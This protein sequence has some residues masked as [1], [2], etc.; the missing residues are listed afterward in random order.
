[1]PPRYRVIVAQPGLYPDP[2]LNRSFGSFGDANLHAMRAQP[3]DVGVALVLTPDQQ[4]AAAYALE[5]G[6][7]ARSATPEET[8]WA[9]EHG[10]MRKA[11]PWR[12]GAVPSK[13]IARSVERKVLPKVLELRA[14]RRDLHDMTEAELNRIIFPPG[15]HPGKHVGLRD[16]FTDE[17]IQH[18]PEHPAWR[19]FS[20]GFKDW[21]F[22]ALEEIIEE[23]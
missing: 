12:T 15:T 17:E 22:A 16:V 2:T 7:R 3:E 11:A 19:E 5:R 10:R 21:V 13:L 6:A 8:A 9:A 1:M 18:L 14:R 23:E 20:R 4:I